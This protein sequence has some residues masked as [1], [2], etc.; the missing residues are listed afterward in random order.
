MSSLSQLPA[1]L[2]P[3][4]QYGRDDVPEPG[5][6]RRGNGQPLA[7]AATEERVAKAERLL[8]GR[9]PIDA[10]VEATGLT[11]QVVEIIRDRVTGRTLPDHHKT[12][13]S[14]VR[15]EVKRRKGVAS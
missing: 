2:H 5:Y 10:I 11:R 7:H 14:Y 15:A 13:K 12:V 4:E 6:Y 8:R 1:L 9:R 3:R